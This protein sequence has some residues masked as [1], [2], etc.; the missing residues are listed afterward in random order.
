MRED[1]NIEMT[2]VD[3]WVNRLLVMLIR[4]WT[5]SEISKNDFSRYMIL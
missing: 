5:E 2:M 1:T 3:P 4:S